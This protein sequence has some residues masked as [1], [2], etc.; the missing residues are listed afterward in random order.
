MTHLIEDSAASAQH[1]SD[2]AGRKNAGQHKRLEEGHQ[3]N[4]PISPKAHR[5]NVGEQ[6]AHRSNRKNS[7]SACFGLNIA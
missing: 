6:A 7:L 5:L 2:G 4:D 1:D 3:A